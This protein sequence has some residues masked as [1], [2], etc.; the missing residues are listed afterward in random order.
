[1]GAENKLPL[2]RREIQ[3]IIE[4][5]EKG[6][7]GQEGLVINALS[8]QGSDA[9]D[10]P[11]GFDGVEAPPGMRLIDGDDPDQR[12]LCINEGVMSP[13]PTLIGIFLDVL[14]PSRIRGILR[15]WLRAY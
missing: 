4:D 7:F 13:G 11:E 6:V 12:M 15:G 3:K 14:P 5:G 10:V 8:S 2:S 1:M 9:P